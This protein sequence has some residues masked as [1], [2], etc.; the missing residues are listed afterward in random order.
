VISEELTQQAAL[1]V[2]LGSIGILL[3]MTLRFND[4]RFG[5]TA[6]VA[7]VHDVLVVIGT[8][9]SLAPSS[10]SRSTRCS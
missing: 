5:A 8:L 1:L 6:L 2:L 3:W 9:P 10:M 7:L 4:F